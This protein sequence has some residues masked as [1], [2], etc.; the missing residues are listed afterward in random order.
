MT[1]RYAKKGNMGNVYCGHPEA[2]RDEI[3]LAETMAEDDST[4]GL[5]EEEVA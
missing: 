3:C 4:C 1:C 5:Y 2:S